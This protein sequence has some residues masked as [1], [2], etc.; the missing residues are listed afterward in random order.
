MKKEKY[1]MVKIWLIITKG[2][3]TGQAPKN[4]NRKKILIISQ[5][6]IFLAGWKKKEENLFFIVRGRE[7]IIKIDVAK[8]ITPPNLLGI[9]RKI[10]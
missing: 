5:N 10:A 3:S 2:Y 6:I 1:K 9:D 8:A 4:V 7:I